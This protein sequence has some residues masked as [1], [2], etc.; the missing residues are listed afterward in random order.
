MAEMHHHDPCPRCQESVVY[1]LPRRP[2]MRWL[3]ASK[4]YE[5]KG[6]GARFLAIRGRAIRL[7]GRRQ[8]RPKED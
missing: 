1:R 6:C 3:P 7:P 5:C 4:Y 8:R 2:W